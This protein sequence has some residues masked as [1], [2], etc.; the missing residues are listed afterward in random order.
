MMLDQ[1]QVLHI[2]KATLLAGVATLLLI[3]Q[4]T[5]SQFYET[6]E[7]FVAYQ[8]Q[9]NRDKIAAKK[10]KKKT[11]INEDDGT[12]VVGFFHPRCSAGGG[13][14]RVLWKSIQALGELKEGKLM[15][16]R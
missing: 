12:F 8:R 10:S 5:R 6:R 14:E 4:Q 9:R 2:I 15:K 3:F 16:R 7:G 13:G 11:D 1:E